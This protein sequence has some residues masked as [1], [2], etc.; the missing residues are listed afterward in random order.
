MLC[1]KWSSAH[2]G[3]ILKVVVNGMLHKDSR[4]CRAG[5]AC[6][7]IFRGVR[8]K[9]KQRIFLVVDYLRRRIAVERLDP[10]TMFL[11]ATTSRQMNSASVFACCGRVRLFSHQ[12]C[13]FTLQF[14]VTKENGRCV[15]T[16]TQPRTLSTVFRD[17]RQQESW[18]CPVYI[19][20][21]QQR[22]KPQMAT[23][24]VQFP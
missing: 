22:S 5:L 16:C 12:C 21:H 15:K 11:Q 1:W 10:W 19:G 9:H 4:S 23:C 3:E 8:P 7:R 6:A 24:S 20:Q 14:W 13:F 18:S 17:E 2:D